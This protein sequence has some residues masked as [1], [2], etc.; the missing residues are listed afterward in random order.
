[1]SD[2]SGIV[3]GW[4]ADANSGNERWWDG[5]AWTDRVR[6]P[7]ALVDDT[8]VGF[9]SCEAESDPADDMQVAS[10]IMWVAPEHRRHGLGTQLLKAIVDGMEED[11][12]TSL[13]L[14]AP[15]YGS[16]D[17]S[18]GCFFGDVFATR[19]G[20]TAR[21]VERCSRAQRAYIDLDLMAEWVRG[22]YRACPWLSGGIVYRS[23]T[24]GVSRPVP[25]G[26]GG[27]GRRSDGRRRLH[28]L[29]P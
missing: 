1:M 26:R 9:G 23:G 29:D 24:G 3:A 18:D 4:Y 28:Q 27:D 19:F 21:Q 25:A 2:G 8:P 12:Q 14:Y 7:L 13:V 16:P 17:G 11:R 10:S 6:Q 15:H 22:G 5:Q 20:L